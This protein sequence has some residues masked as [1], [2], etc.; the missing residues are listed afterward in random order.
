MLNYKIWLVD[1][2]GDKR[3]ISYTRLNAL[4]QIGAVA[5]VELGVDCYIVTLRPA[6]LNRL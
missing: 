3:V 2:T 6:Q 1:E 4:L 5:R